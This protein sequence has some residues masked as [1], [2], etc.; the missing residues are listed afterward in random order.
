MYKLTPE[1][2]RLL[3][4]PWL[5]AAAI[6]I[7][8]SVWTLGFYWASQTPADRTLY[9]WVGAPVNLDEKLQSKITDVG[10]AYGMKDISIAAYDPADSQ[11]PAAFAFQ[12][13]TTDIFILRRDEAVTIAQAGVFMPLDE[14]YGDS[15]AAVRYE[16]SVIGVTFKEEYCVLVCA[17]SKKDKSMLYDV[18]KA[19]VEYGNSVGEKSEE[20]V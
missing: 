19:V 1:M 18:V 6:I 12:T 7:A 16:D 15:H 10:K 17:Y 11:Y 4:K 20:S 9:V 2:K 5:W 13:T 14:V 8:A 3:K